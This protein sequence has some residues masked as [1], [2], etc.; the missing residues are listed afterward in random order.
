M[1]IAER[2]VQQWRRH[3]ANVEL[4]DRSAT[5]Q[6]TGSDFWC[7]AWR[8][9]EGGHINPLALTRG[10]A[11]A[12]R[13]LG[14]EV[15]HQSPV[16]RMFHNGQC[17][18]ATTPKGQ[19]RAQA[20]VLATHA[21]TDAFALGLHPELAREVVPAHS[22][23]LATKPLSPAQRQRVLPSRSALSDTQGDLHFTRYDARHRLVSGAAL[24]SSIN[25]VP[26]LKALVGRRLQRMFPGIAT[27]EFDY[28]WSGFLGMTN[29]Y[30]PRV[31]RIGP[32]GYT[33]AGCN[34]RGLGL[35]VSLGRELA[36]AAL[37][38][39]PKTLALPLEPIRPIRQ[40]TLA[41]RLGP[42]KL[43]AYR[44]RDARELR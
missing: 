7:G 4:L 11:A 5:A 17:W 15:F 35:A 34:G 38:D 44:W 16:Q 8:V 6:C 43:L 31:H 12:V 33:W 23:M 30:T 22:W 1:R 28:V 41:R 42:L 27:V 39:D 24:L 26:R 9:P 25:A 32:M 10:L 21:L 29:D 14:A 20:L 19:V 3:G 36:R 2:R 37:G 13:R 18:V 40:H